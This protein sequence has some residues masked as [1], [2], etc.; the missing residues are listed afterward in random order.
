[1]LN[2]LIRFSL[3]NRALVI[4]LAIVLMALG[5]RTTMTMPVEVLRGAAA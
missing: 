2:K 4:G 3:Q 1:M 5:V